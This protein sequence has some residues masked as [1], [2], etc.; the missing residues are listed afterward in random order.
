MSAGA[1]R[2]GLLGCGRIGQMHAAL[3]TSRVAGVMP[4]PFRNR[5]GCF[6]IS[7]MCAW[8][9]TAQNGITSSG[10]HQTA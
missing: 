1:L 4:L 8:R 2:I 3:L 6:E 7:Q 9:V 10:S 5:Y